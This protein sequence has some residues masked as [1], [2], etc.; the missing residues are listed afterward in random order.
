LLHCTRKAALYDVEMSLGK[1]IKAARERLEPRMTQGKLGEHFG[2]SD[3]AVSGW[4]RD[5][6]RPDLEK[7]AKLARI[8]KV[9]ARWLLDGKGHP[10]P[11]DAL[12][13]VMDQLDDEGRA[14]LE[15]MAQTLLQRRGSAA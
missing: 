14:L 7:I 8:L 13:S 2:V 6:D 3:K 11:P 5:A 15:A 1:R 12:E 10:P 4:E 9:P